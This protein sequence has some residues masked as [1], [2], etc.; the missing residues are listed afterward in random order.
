MIGGHSHTELREPILVLCEKP[1]AAPESPEDCPR[2]VAAA[3]NSRVLM[4]YDFPELY[5][6]LTERV[7]DHLDS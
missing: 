3:R 6:P 7:M 1:M 4:L 2:I 5:D